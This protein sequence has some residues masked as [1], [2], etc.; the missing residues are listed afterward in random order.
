MAKYML[1]LGGA[2]LDKRSGNTAIATQ[3]FERFATWLGALRASGRYVDSMK[4]HDQTGARLTVRG[5]QVV[6]G[7][8]IETKEAVGGVFIVEA[9]SLDEAIA[10][11]RECPTL[12]LQNGFVEVRVV[13][14]VSRRL[15]A[16]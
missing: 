13:E 3:M 1:L 8:F 12:T 2:D 4:L 6:E 14:E 11:A 5:G 7:P 9:A 10:M 16:R 15:P